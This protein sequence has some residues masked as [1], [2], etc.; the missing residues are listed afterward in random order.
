VGVRQ[1]AHGLSAAGK[2]NVDLMLEMYL[3][4]PDSFDTVG[5][6][7][8]PDLT[9]TVP[10][11]THGDLATAAITVNCIPALFEMRPGL[12]TSKD[13]PMSYFPGV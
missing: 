4:A 13:T 12:R 9:L 3:G 5:V 6:T 7:G 10:G 11:G 2:V 8:T 1:V